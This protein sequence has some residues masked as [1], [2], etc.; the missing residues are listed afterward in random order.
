MLLTPG[1]D[2]I[3]NTLLNKH[4]SLPDGKPENFRSVEIKDELVVRI[5]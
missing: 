4:N 1:S 2:A 5:N 3:L